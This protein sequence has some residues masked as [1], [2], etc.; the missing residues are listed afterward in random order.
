MQLAR[1]AQQQQHTV[2][3][4]PP[5]P[6]RPRTVAALLQLAAAAR[7]LAL[8]RIHRRHHDLVP[9]ASRLGCLLPPLLLLWLLLWLLLLWLLLWLLLL[10]LLSLRL[11]LGQLLPLLAPQL[12]ELGRS[13]HAHGLLDKEL[14]LAAADCMQGTVHQGAGWS[15]GGAAG[16]T[17]GE[18]ATANLEHITRCGASNSRPSARA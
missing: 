17:A 16:R 13:R 12:V 9:L 11:L 5:Q 6:G 10:L 7:L 3:W 2:Q 1:C 4:P 15:A 14:H 18:L 8:A